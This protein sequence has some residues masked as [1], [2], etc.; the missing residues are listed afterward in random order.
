MPVARHLLGAPAHLVLLALRYACFSTYCVRYSGAVRGPLG[1]GVLSPLLVGAA[2]ISSDDVVF[3]SANARVE[4][5]RS[6]A[7]GAEE[8]Y[9][10]LRFYQTTYFLFH[11]QVGQ[12]RQ[13]EMG[14]I[15]S[16]GTMFSRVWWAEARAVG[17]DPANREAQA[18]FAG[19]SEKGV[20]IRME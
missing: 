7:L 2:L 5:D 4:V 8:D 14:S 10:Q 3:Q 1:G 12:L 17:L 15:S 13:R 9:G 19:P 6:F 18:F 11:E 16:I 20:L